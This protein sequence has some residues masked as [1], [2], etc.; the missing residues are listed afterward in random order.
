MPASP[1]TDA[2][3]QG[4]LRERIDRLSNELA[5]LAPATMSGRIAEVRAM[6]VEVG[7]APLGAI[8][9]RLEAAVA[10]GA[11]PIAARPFVEALRDA[12]VLGPADAALSQSILASVNLRL[13]GFDR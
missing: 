1:K 12:A 4:L 11:G 2:E 8:T 5:I 13:A 6:A 9:R 7:W 10:S 3:R